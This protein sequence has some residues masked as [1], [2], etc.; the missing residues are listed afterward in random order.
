MNY[1]GDA[2]AVLWVIGLILYVRWE[3]KYP[4]RY[5][6]GKPAAI[7]VRLAPLMLFLCSLA[8]MVLSLALHDYYYSALF[9][10]FLAA[11]TL[12]ASAIYGFGRRFRR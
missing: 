7:V 5:R 4:V 11:V 8:L 10:L 9:V 12:L 6:H 3:I 2:G 1:S